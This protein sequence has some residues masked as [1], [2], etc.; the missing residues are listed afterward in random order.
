MRTTMKNQ[1]M[2]QV[3]QVLH[4]SLKIQ[5]Q[6]LHIIPM[7]IPALQLVFK[8]VTI[9]NISRI[10]SNSIQDWHYREWSMSRLNPTCQLDHEVEL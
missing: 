8:T 6:H 10:L 9:N 3:E 1:T 5:P 2:N 7:G 4:P